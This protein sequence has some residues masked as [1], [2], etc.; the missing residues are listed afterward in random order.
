MV[1]RLAMLELKLEFFEMGFV[2]HKRETVT[3]GSVQ[4]QRPILCFIHGGIG[5]GKSTIMEDCVDLMGKES[6][7]FVPE[8]IFVSP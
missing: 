3:S 5:A 1:D 6:V 2:S 7:G 8:P 4:Q